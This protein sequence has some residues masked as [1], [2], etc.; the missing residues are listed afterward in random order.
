[1][2]IVKSLLSEDPQETMTK[3]AYRCP[4]DRKDNKSRGFETYIYTLSTYQEQQMEHLVYV[5]MYVCMYV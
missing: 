3:D 2:Y 5:C 4:K 1:M